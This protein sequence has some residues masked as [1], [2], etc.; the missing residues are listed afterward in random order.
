M[1]L[2]SELKTYHF[3]VAANMYYATPNS[4]PILKLKPKPWFK[5]LCHAKILIDVGINVM[6]V[7]LIVNTKI[8]ISDTPKS[9]S[10]GLQTWGCETDLRHSC[11]LSVVGIQTLVGGEVGI[12]RDSIVIKSNRVQ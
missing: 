4:Q 7:L 2:N 9:K 1:K 6:S 11:Q 12:T 10:D 5:M 3:L 8:N